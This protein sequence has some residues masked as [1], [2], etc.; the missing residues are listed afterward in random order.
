MPFQIVCICPIAVDIDFGRCFLI[1]LLV[2]PG[3]DV[4]RIGAIAPLTGQAF[5]VYFL[6][7]RNSLKNRT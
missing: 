5:W 4:N 2:R 3:N 6:R 1:A 7:G